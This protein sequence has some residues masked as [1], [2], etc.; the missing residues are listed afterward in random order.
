MHHARPSLIK[1][2]TP[3]F[4]PI[5]A[6]TTP[7][8]VPEVRLSLSPYSLFYP[9]CYP[10]P[11]FQSFK[12]FK[13]SV[14]SQ[15]ICLVRISLLTEP[16]G[17]PRS[18]FQVVCLNY[19]YTFSPLQKFHFSTTRNPRLVFFVFYRLLHIPRYFPLFTYPIPRLPSTF[20]VENLAPVKRKIRKKSLVTLLK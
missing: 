16:S 1:F 2:P 12:V 18:W 10:T 20:L 3:D 14:V 6:Q 13:V 5:S 7:Q 4:N 19:K 15:S 8:L 11:F 9:L 17:P